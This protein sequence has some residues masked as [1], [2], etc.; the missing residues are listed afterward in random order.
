MKK[1]ERRVITNKK[2]AMVAIQ[3]RGKDSK[4]TVV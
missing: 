4:F 1:T 3:G 2:I